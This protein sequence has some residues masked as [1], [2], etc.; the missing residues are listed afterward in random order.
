MKIKLKKIYIDTEICKQFADKIIDTEVE[1]I[2]FD[3]YIGEFNVEIEEKVKLFNEDIEIMIIC[4]GKLV[5]I[6]RENKFNNDT[7]AEFIQY[8]IYIN[9]MDINCYANGEE[10]E[11]NNDEF[12]KKIE[13]TINK[14]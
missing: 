13:T 1:P 11:F 12:Y 3:E 6:G 8:G 7:P 10:V 2:G 4:S 9:N 5:Q 14:Q